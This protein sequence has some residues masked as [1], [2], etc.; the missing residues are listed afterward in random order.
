MASFTEF[1]SR[2]TGQRCMHSVVID[3]GPAIDIQF[4]AVVREQPKLIRRSRR[5]EKLPDVVDG[6][7]FQTASDSGKALLKVSRGHVQ[8]SRVD[9]ANR[10]Q[11]LE[12]GD[13]FAI[14]VNEVDPAAKS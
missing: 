7:P 4:G 8:A 1:H 13:F 14:R 10:L 12:I 11:T 6:K 2:L 5:N 3:D 9:G